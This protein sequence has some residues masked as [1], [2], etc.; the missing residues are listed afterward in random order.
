MRGKKSA[1]DDTRVYPVLGRL[2]GDNVF[3]KCGDKG[4]FTLA[5]ICPQ[6]VLREFSRSFSKFSHFFLYVF[7]LEVA[8]LCLWKGAS[9]DLQQ[10]AC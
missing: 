9:G 1:Q 2:L 5:E 8:V 10:E 7:N 3:Q 6:E 4:R